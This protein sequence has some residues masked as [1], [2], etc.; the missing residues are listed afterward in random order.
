[1]RQE[2]QKPRYARQFWAFR[3]ETDELKWDDR[4]A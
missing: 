4:Y 2:D 1:M 3:K